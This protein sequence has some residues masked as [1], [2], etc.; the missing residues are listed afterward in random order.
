MSGESNDEGYMNCGILH[1]SNLC[2]Y[3]SSL[4]N[5]LHTCCPDKGDPCRFL[6]LFGVEIKK[7]A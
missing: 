5:P 4:A 6:G 2:I 3:H 1:L 7:T